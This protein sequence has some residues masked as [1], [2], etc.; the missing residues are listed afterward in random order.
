MVQAAL[1]PSVRD[2]MGCNDVKR[3]LSLLERAGWDR[4]SKAFPDGTPK[5][6][7]FTFQSR[8]QLK[9]SAA[10][11][12]DWPMVNV[13][14]P[15]GLVSIRCRPVRCELGLEGGLSQDLERSGSDVP[16]PGAGLVPGLL[17]GTP[18]AGSASVDRSAEVSGAV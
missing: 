10:R 11:W 15:V 14:V 9:T 5:D 6:Y 12:K 17:S 2:R 16:V 3:E 8:E 1:G 7:D 18:M 13:G 4:A